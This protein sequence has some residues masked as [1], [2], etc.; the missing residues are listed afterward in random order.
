MR[1]WHGR[2]HVVTV[3]KEGFSYAGATYPS[4][5][6]IAHMITGTHWSGPRFFGLTRKVARQADEPARLSP[7]AS[8]RLVHKAAAEVHHG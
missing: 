6:K 8:K 2:T 3:T 7:R 4:V 5:T 1:E